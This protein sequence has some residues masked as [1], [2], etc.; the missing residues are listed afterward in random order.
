[1]W[2]IDIPFGSSFKKNC[3]IK[4]SVL[5]Y[6]TVQSLV[7]LSHNMLFMKSIDFHRLPFILLL[8]KSW[9]KI[10]W[11]L[12]QCY[13]S[14]EAKKTLSSSVTLWAN[15]LRSYTKAASFFWTL[16]EFA[17]LIQNWFE[18]FQIIACLIL[19]Q[20]IFV[21][22]MAELLFFHLGCRR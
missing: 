3:E 21:F 22:I 4:G 9:M 20:N 12:W 7:A 17:T 6:P 15:G 19:I 10:Y 14:I 2:C 8:L 16:K 18:C 5:D 13:S 1:M 11:A